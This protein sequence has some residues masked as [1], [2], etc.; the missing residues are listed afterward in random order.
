M[1][2]PRALAILLATISPA[3]GETSYVLLNYDIDSLVRISS[4]GRTVTKIASKVGGVGLA[5]EASGAYIVGARTALLRVTRKG[6]VTQLAQAPADAEWG[7]IVIAPSGDIIVADGK[8]PALWRVSLDG[9]SAVKFST[10]MGIVYPSG[11]RV[12]A[13]AVDA[14][15]NYHWLIQ[16]VKDH[17][18]G[19]ETQ[20][21]QV[22]PSGRAAEIALKGP[23]TYSPTAV[24]AVGRGKYLFIDHDPRSGFGVWR[25]TPEGDVSKLASLADKSYPFG[26]ARNPETGQL[27]VSTRDSGLSR[28][29]P[30]GSVVEAFVDLFMRTRVWPFETAVI[31]EQNN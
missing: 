10:V 6:V 17:R 13:V 28:I 24:I 12:T 18:R 21:F 9:S 3:L 23:R 11:G 15:G 29:S 26:I 4:D 14:S 19:G 31:A 16:G 7:A 22:T 1:K 27:V 8:T 30:D 2:S 25:L 20:Y 5:V